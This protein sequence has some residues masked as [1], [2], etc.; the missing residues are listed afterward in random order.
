MRKAS[1]LY[2]L[3]VIIERFNKARDWDKF[4]SPKNL[5]EALSVEA[6]ELMEIF[7][8]MPENESFTLDAQKLAHLKEEIGDV[9]IYLMSISDLFG[10]DPTSAAKDKV[11]LNE[12]R[13]PV[14]VVKGSAKKYSEY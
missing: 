10:I 9:M 11:K 6:A 1:P 14:D 5:A 7:Q 4:H 2:E 8:W 13:Y 3:N 12:V